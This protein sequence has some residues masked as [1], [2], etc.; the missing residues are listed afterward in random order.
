MIVHLSEALLVTEDGIDVQD[1]KRR[2]GVFCKAYKNPNLRCISFW[3]TAGDL[4]NAKRLREY[5][6]KLRQDLFRAENHRISVLIDGE[7]R[8]FD[9]EVKL[10]FFLHATIVE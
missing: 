10:P 5:N 7:I 8:L 6:E 9:L 4:P 1:L 3:L 2:I